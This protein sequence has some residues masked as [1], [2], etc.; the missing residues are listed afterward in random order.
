MIIL[1][2]E[3]EKTLLHEFL[4]FMVE[5]LPT[6]EEQKK[7]C[8]SLNEIKPENVSEFYAFFY[9]ITGKK[10]EEKKYKVELKPGVYVLTTY[11]NSIVIFAFLSAW[12]SN[13]DK[14]ICNYYLKTY[15]DAKNKMKIQQP[16]YN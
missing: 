9:S 10:L 13:F 7:F 6:I 14:P 15:I 3:Q 5:H 8:N 11:E 16:E 12:F 4:Q 1:D 2:I